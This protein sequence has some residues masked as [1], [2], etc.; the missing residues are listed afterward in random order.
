MMNDKNP[1]GGFLFAA[2]YKRS[3]DNGSTLPRWQ[4]TAGLLQST[5][6]QDNGYEPQQAAIRT[7]MSENTG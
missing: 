6:V 2:M 3:V 7:G 5:V 1:R 4:V